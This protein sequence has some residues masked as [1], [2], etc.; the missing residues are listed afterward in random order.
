MGD[1]WYYLEPACASGT[2]IDV[3]GASRQTNANVQCWSSNGRQGQAFRFS[4]SNGYFTVVNA[5]SGLALDVANSDLLSGANVTQWPNDASQ[6]N[7][8]FSINKNS[9]GTITLINRA[10]GLAL[11]A[12]SGKSGA[13][14]SA[15]TPNGTSSQAFRLVAVSSPLPSGIYT[16]GVNSGTSSVVDLA[17]PSAADGTGCVVWRNSGDLNQRW[18]IQVVSGRNGAYTIESL[19]SS[20]RLCAN[21]NG[22]VS[23]SPAKTGD[24]SQIWIAELHDGYVSFRSAAYSQKQ[25]DVTG[26]GSASGT[27]IGIW[28]ANSSGA[29]RFVPVLASG[30]LPNG[31]YL[32]RSASDYRQVIDVKNASHDNCANVLSWSNNGGG[33]QKWRAARNSDGR[34]YVYEL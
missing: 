32:V 13:N 11:D 28:N 30:D 34:L 21:S 5:G 22:T 26:G 6:K 16:I 14:V 2:S 20:K 29:Q 15:C 9:D 10:A 27:K 23:Q 4:Y 19:N 7:R 33:N 31:T 3:Y 24:D 25:L 17:G 8:Q 12:G 18:C 1:G